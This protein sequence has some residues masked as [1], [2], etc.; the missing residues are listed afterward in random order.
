MEHFDDDDEEDDLYTTYLAP[1]LEHN[2]LRHNLKT[3]KEREKYEV[4][5]CLVSEA[6]GTGFAENVSSCYTV[7]K[8]NLD[9]LV[10]SLSSW[11]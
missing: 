9:V 5:G 8:A 2:C 11:G 3:L 4:R 10:S 6:V 7:L 1:V